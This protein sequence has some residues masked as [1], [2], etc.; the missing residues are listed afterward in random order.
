M[1]S[2]ALRRNEPRQAPPRARA[3]S[4]DGC[5]PA[6]CDAPRARVA[7]DPAEAPVDK[8]SPAGFEA[9][10]EGLDVRRLQAHGV[11]QWLT[12]EATCRFLMT[13]RRSPAAAPSSALQTMDEKITTATR[14]LLR[15]LLEELD[16]VDDLVVRSTRPRSAR[17]TARSSQTRSPAL[18]DEATLS[19]NAEMCPELCEPEPAQEQRTDLAEVA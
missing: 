15:V 10:I 13:A 9:A 16:G 7:R 12:S 1:T 17:R 5:Q 2:S 6:P 3:R 11:W 19:R 4:A 8:A 14:D 18:S